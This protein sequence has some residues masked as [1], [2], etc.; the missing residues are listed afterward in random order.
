ML[1]SKI[2]LRFLLSFLYIINYYLKVVTSVLN[3][4][5]LHKVAYKEMVGQSLDL[6][7]AAFVI[8]VLPFKRR[9]V[10]KTLS[11]PDC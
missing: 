11:I 8:D 10:L 1:M 9:T 3:L 7:R 5:C 6:R 2:L 4:A